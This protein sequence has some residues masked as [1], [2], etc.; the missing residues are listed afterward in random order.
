MTAEETLAL[1]E[2]ATL[3]LDEQRLRLAG[4]G[5][6]DAIEALAEEVGSLL[7]RLDA[8]GLAAS[9]QATRLHA[10]AQ[11]A[12]A[13]L[14]EAQAALLARRAR[15]NADQARA[16]RDGV[17]LKHYHSAPPTG[18]SRFLDERR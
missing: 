14:V 10:A 12:G 17:A 11:G 2:R 5:D 6:L 4:D 9:A 15:L 16:E 13:A 18:E 3:L 1:L 8:T 7:A